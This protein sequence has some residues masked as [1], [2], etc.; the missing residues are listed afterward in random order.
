MFWFCPYAHVLCWLAVPLLMIRLA[1]LPEIFEQDID[2]HLAGY[3]A[4]GLAAHAVTHDEDA[5][6]RIVAEVIFVVRTNATYVSFASD[7]Y[8]ERHLRSV[9]VLPG[10]GVAFGTIIAFSA[11]IGGEIRYC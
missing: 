5:I 11:R 8:S 3:F 4:G 7:F 9:C 6:A 10:L 2:S 1:L